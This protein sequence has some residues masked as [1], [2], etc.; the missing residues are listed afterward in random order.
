MRFLID[1][2]LEP[3]RVFAALK[4][5]PSFWLPLSLSIVLTVVMTLMYFGKV[6][7]EW[8]V[9]HQLAAS[10]KEMSASEIA[11]AKQV[12]PSA[13]TMGYIGAP[14]GALAIAFI[15]ALM[16][17]YYMLAG[18]ITGAATSFRHGLSLATWS[19]MPG[20]LGL[21]VAIIGIVGMSPQTSLESLMLTNFD[22]LLVQLPLDHAWNGLAERF[23]LLSLWSIFL[24]AL[25]WRTW[26]RT[27]WAEAV[28]V[29]SIP[30]VLVYGVMAIFA[31]LKS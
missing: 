28:T 21:V 19:G 11:Q 20:L 27:S 22:P 8:F 7:S 23:S 12:M 25:G 16:A 31:L 26:G 10:G 1:I 2:F 29:A 18:R 14:V 24:A 30:S 3:G 15:S 5:K 17:L 9:D 6:D 13:R 4:D